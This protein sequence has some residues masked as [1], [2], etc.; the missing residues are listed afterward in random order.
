MHH[1]CTILRSQ[2]CP[3]KELLTQAVR[4]SDL[5]AQN[6]LFI[7]QISKN[8]KEIISLG[9]DVCLAGNRIHNYF[10][11]ADRYRCFCANESLNKPASQS[12]HNVFTKVM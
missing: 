11:E 1:H 2:V 9:Q 4:F 5:G 7:A 12:I 3:S 10:G 8:S 6:L